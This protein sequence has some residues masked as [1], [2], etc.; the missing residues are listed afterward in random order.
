MLDEDEMPL[1]SYLIAHGD[2]SLSTEQKAQ[3]VDWA[4]AVREELGYVPEEKK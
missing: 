3:I 2:A 4:K 1:K